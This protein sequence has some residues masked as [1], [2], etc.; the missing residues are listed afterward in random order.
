VLI[1]VLHQLDGCEQAPV[2]TDED[3][4]AMAHDLEQNNAVQHAN[5]SV[6]EPMPYTDPIGEQDMGF[7]PVLAAL[8]IRRGQ[9]APPDNVYYYGLLDS[10]DGFPGGLLGQALGIPEALPELANQRVAT[11]RWLGSGA[12]AAETFTHEIGHSQG[13]RHV[14]CSGG[15]G[16]PELDY[17]HDNG[18]IGIWGFGIHDFELRPPTKARDYMTYCT[19][20]FVSDYGWE[21]TLDV[22]EILTGWDDADVSRPDD[23]RVLMGIVHD[24]GR[25]VWWTAP[26]TVS[27]AG[28]AADLRMVWTVEGLEHAT[29]VRRDALPDALPDALSD[30]SGMVVVAAMPEA[31]AAASSVR[32]EQAGGPAVIV[33]RAALRR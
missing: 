6:G 28:A 5:V 25:A 24:D 27:D 21:Q 2:P 22:I 10:C 8:A 17:P 12:A 4:L 31:F 3:V 23:G 32:L 19:N 26:G 18:R 29:I 11:G 13:R 9:D 33:D 16:G 1:P 14:T 15:E 30:G 20:A 7:S